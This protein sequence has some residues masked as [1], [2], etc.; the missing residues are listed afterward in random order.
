MGTG[1]APQLSVL[2]READRP[3]HAPPGE[4]VARTEPV[5]DELQGDILAILKHSKTLR[6]AFSE[7]PRSHY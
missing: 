6:I 1:L 3:P 4:C 2:R 7:F 5:W